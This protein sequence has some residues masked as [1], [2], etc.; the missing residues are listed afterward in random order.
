M[1]FTRFTRS[2]LLLTVGALVAG[3]SAFVAAAGQTAAK[4]AVRPV[5]QAAKAHAAEVAAPDF[6]MI[7]QYCITCHSERMKS[8]G[9]VLEKRD[10]S[11]IGAEAEM[12]ER[13]AKKLRARSMPPIN[14]RR[15]DQATM[16]TFV[17]SLEAT[18]DKTA[19]AVPNPGRAPIHR[20]NR[21]EYTNAVRDLLGLE[22]DGKAMLPAD[23]TG[24]GFD[25][26]ADVLTVS[27]G[28]FERYMLAAAKVSRLAVEDPTMRAKLTSYELPYLSLG[29]DERMNEL[30]P[31]G[32]RGGTAIRHYFPLD[33]EYEVRF[34][35]QRNDLAAGYNVRG[36]SAPTAIDVRIDRQRIKIFNLGGKAARPMYSE[37]ADPEYPDEGLSVKFKTTAGTHVVSI[38]LN[39]DVWKAEGVSVGQ[40]PLTNNGY[41]QGRDTTPLYGRIDAGIEKV[42]ITG[43]FDGKAPKG[44][45]LQRK[46][47]VCQPAAAA[48]EEPCARRIMGRLARLAYRRPV[49][50][51]DLKTLMEFYRKG[52]KED[53]S[54]RAGIQAS[55]GRLLVDPNFLFRMEL[56]PAGVKPGSA[57]KVSDLDLASRLSF[58]L[59]SSIPDEELLTVAAAGQLKSPIVLEKQVRRMLADPR[60]NTMIDNFF[61][62]WL[63]IKNVQSAHPDP[64][65]FPEFDENLRSAFIEETK[66]FLRSQV[67]EDRSAAE[68]ITANY[69][70]V[71]ERLARHYGI[72]G[73]VG[74][75]FRR[76]N[77]PDDKRAGL[78][79][80][81]SVL[82]VT[83]YNDRTSVVLRGKFIMDMFLGT[84]PPA[85]P[86]NVPPLENTK[87]EGTLRQ[88]M[89]LHRKNPVCASCHNTIDPM[90]FAFENFDGVGKYRTLDSRSPI[91]AT[92][93][94]ADGSKFDGAAS[95]RKA[96]YDRK[97][98]F[99]G[100]M[101]RN[102]MTYAM[103][104][105]V[106]TFD[107]PAVRKILRDTQPQDYKWS[108]IVLGIVKS[109]P[110]QMRRAES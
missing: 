15:P 63:T 97:E 103:G 69:T 83:S 82:M 81:G 101:V 92:G 77:L 68:L 72:P 86:A 21:F 45:E 36:L 85:P 4:P 38:A 37:G 20:L 104:R 25:N 34:T 95:F 60:S 74:N 19:L 32:S 58:F 64:K 8:G 102:M 50:E 46:I 109:M 70:F 61:A 52:R 76:V 49:G 24:Y 88:R 96:L 79:G 87:I 27:P 57:Y 16:A 1:M 41:S 48:T 51:S 78:L 89:E 9:L 3:A 107:M 18:L 10:P 62:Q 28:L 29:Q 44:S 2:R 6:A 40:L 47:F 65:V 53:G 67:R 7:N 99:L 17:Q 5:A 31:F 33:G 11:K 66:L 39:Q 35:L 108:S 59:W 91:N 106:E 26:I 73:V 98:A 105:G 90:G 23:D 55:I 30:Q 42:D 43:P 22:I 56:D 110:F 54:F 84:Q 80:Q 100:A 75:H 13:V 71:N 93:A 94:L 12:W 14:S